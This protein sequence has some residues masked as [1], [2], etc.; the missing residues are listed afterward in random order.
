MFELIRGLY[1]DQNREKPAPR[2]LRYRGIPTYPSEAAYRLFSGSFRP[3]VSGSDDPFPVFMDSPRSHLVSWLP[4]ADPPR[5]YL[6]AAHEVCVTIQGQRA[7]KA[8]CWNDPVGLSYQSLDRQGMAPCQRSLAVD[9]GNLLLIDRGARQIVPLNSHW[10]KVS[11][12]QLVEIA[13]ATCDWRSVFE[14][15]APAVSPKEAFG[16]VLLYPDDD[17]EIGELATQPFAADYLQDLVEQDKPLAA[18]VGRAA[19]LLVS[20]F[21]ATITT[22]IRSGSARVCTVLYDHPAYAQRQAQTL[23][24]MYARAQRLESLSH[25]RM[26]PRQDNN[27]VEYSRKY[28]LSFEWVPFGFYENSDGVRKRIEWLARMLAPGAIAFVVGPPS[29]ADGCRAAKLQVQVIT[30]LL[31]LPTFQMHQTILPRAR[32]KAGAML[33]QIARG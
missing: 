8:T 29:V 28:D 32:L 22:C 17:R 25:V 6:D 31:E 16:A 30:P 7:M 12:P 14:G 27:E 3:E 2:P 26:R 11:G 20:G 5:R 18:Q 4:L 1:D 9:R 13:L 23:W 21:D 15:D 24:N 33:Y 19:H 10:G